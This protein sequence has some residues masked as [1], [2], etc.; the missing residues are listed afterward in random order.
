MSR[1]CLGVATF[2]RLILAPVDWQ[3]TG[4]TIYFMLEN[5]AGA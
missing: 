5:L 4:F 3:L 2:G 1:R